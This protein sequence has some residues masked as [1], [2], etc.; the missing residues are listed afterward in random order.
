MKALICRQS[1]ESSAKVA[2]RFVPPG[3]LVDDWESFEKKIESL[4][5]LVPTYSAVIS[6]KG[7]VAFKL[8]RV[9]TFFSIVR[10]K[11]LELLKNKINILK[12]SVTQI[13]DGNMDWR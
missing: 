4:P 13:Q 5:L 10:R 8:N 2:R 3:G 6:P 11:I 9:E 1:A 12:K 7:T